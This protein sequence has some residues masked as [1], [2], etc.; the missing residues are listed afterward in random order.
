V[1]AEVRLQAPPQS[2]LEVGRVVL[3]ATRELV[4]NPDLADTEP[5]EPIS[6]W[7]TTTDAPPPP[8]G[9]PA[10]RASPHRNAVELENPTDGTVMLTQQVALTP[11][12]RFS[13]VFDGESRTA[14]EGIALELRWLDDSAV[15]DAPEVALALDKNTLSPQLVAGTVP[16]GVSRAELRLV[17]P[18]TSD[19]LLRRV[20]LQTE[21]ATTTAVDVLA[22][23]PGDLKVRNAVV[24]YD[25]EDAAPA[26]VPATGLCTPTPPGRRPGE[27]EHCDYCPCC[28]RSQPLSDAVDALTPGGRPALAGRC[29]ECG[30]ERVHLGG[31]ARV[32]EPAALSAR[33]PLIVRLASPL[34]PL[35]SLSRIHG[36]GRV[37]GQALIAAGI[38][39]V[40]RLA[41][42][43]PDT[44]RGLLRGGLSD[45]GIREILG[46]ARRLAGEE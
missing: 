18:P 44:L 14:R 17:L 9:S 39:S 43:N 1:Q 34:E 8:A 20:S 3:A 16:D 2:G 32:G 40:E 12:V 23:A 15:P 22:H 37:R 11:G 10:F 6:G 24:A 7:T 45:A 35:E 46:E 36:I 28:G 26:P 4:A 29:A 33:M 27:P 41:A 5:G 30:T 25:I 31:A 13:L 42:E 19:I 38:D 21:R